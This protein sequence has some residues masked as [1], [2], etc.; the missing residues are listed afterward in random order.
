M[1]QLVAGLLAA[2]LLAGCTER[3]TAEPVRLPER[4]EVAA[5]LR[6][7]GLESE[8]KLRRDGRD[9]LEFASPAGLR[10]LSMTIDRNFV[11][12]RHG[13]LERRFTRGSLPADSVAEILLSALDTAAETG[14]PPD[15]RCR[16][17]SGEF[18]L[19]TEEG[20]GNILKLSIPEK[21]LE[22]EVQGFRNLGQSG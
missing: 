3:Q 19:K 11:N 6:Y 14:I 8:V 15:G 18:L 4:Y 20:S 12:L 21:G 10:G 1:K 17:S 5:R 9:T 16:G 7:K 22:L 13:D 2:A